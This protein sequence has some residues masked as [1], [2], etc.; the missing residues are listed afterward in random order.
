M[1]NS[2]ADEEPM[3]RLSFHDVFLKAEKC[4]TRSHERY[5]DEPSD[6]REQKRTN[7]TTFQ[8]LKLME[9]LHLKLL[10]W[11]KTHTLVSVIG[12]PRS[13]LLCLTSDPRDS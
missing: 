8:S 12:S 5:A 1:F 9:H 6:I 3:T 11:Q 2:D 4:R 10:L 13:H 7:S